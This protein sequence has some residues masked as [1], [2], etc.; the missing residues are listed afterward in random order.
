MFNRTVNARTFSASSERQVSLRYW[1]FVFV[2]LYLCSFTVRYL[3]VKG[4]SLRDTNRQEKYKSR[5]IKLACQMFWDVV[6]QCERCDQVDKEADGSI[7]KHLC[8][9]DVWSKE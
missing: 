9:T 8:R 5:A 4:M 1:L 2:F 7:V 3:L 6:G